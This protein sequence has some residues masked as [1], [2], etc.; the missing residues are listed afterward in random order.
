[1]VCRK[2]FESQSVRD[3]PGAVYA[4][5]F[6]ACTGVA[7]AKS[8][9]PGWRRKLALEL[10][11]SLADTSYHKPSNLRIIV[12][13]NEA[14]ESPGGMPT[15]TAHGVDLVQVAKGCG[16]KKGFTVSS[17]EDFREKN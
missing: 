10:V 16:I 14:Y 8:F 13:D 7:E 12:F 11:H 9:C 17:I 4:C 2:T 15:A 5:R 6:G 1:M 3:E